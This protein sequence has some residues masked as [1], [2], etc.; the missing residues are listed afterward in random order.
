MNPK[1]VALPRPPH[2]EA[3][4]TMMFKASVNPEKPLQDML[5]RREMLALEL[6]RLDAEIERYAYESRCGQRDDTQDVELYDGSLGVP[7]EFVKR[8][9]PSVGQLQ[10]LNDLHQRFDGT[11]ESPGDVTGVRWGSGGLFTDDLFITAGHCFDQYGGG[12]QR[13]SRNGMTIEPSEIATLMQVNFNFQ[14]NGQ[15]NQERPAGGVIS[16]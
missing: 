10:W 6:G 2:V 11:T 9:E 7:Q 14:L 13:P 12:W 5:R 8:Y 16:C 1:P 4:A 3:M 15:T